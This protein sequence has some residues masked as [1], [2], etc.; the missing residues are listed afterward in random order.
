MQACGGGHPFRVVASAAILVFGLFLA[1]F[2]STGS[3]LV[4]VAFQSCG[5]FLMGLTYGPIGTAL[6]EMFPP[7]VR[8]TGASLC[9][10]IAGI[11][12]AS[13]TPF[14]ATTLATTYGLSYVGYYLSCGAAI[15]I[16]ALL[17]A[18]SLIA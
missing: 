18:R 1:P 15:S 7:E 16:A 11:L 10:T 17:G 5:L 4:T 3:L 13:L 9:F 2:F 12:G 8:Y 6:A 14:L